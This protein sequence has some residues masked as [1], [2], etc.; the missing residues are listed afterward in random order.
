VDE[1]PVKDGS[2][3]GFC[4]DVVKRTLESPQIVP[5]DFSAPELRTGR[6]RIGLPEESFSTRGFDTFPPF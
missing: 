4:G 6:I 1:Y 5:E 3:T 2:G